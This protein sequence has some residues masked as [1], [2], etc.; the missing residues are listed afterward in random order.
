[1]IGTM[2]VAMSW[3]CGCSSEA[4]AASPWFL[5]IITYSSRVVLREI[6]HPVP[7]SARNTAARCSGPRAAE[8]RVV[9]ASR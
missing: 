5:K 3:E 7:V 1:M 4:P 6:Q 2:G 9:R 8:R